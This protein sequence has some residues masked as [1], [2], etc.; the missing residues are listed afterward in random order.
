MT[1]TEHDEPIAPPP[2]S[3]RWLR[4]LIAIA[5]V[6]AIVGVLA[7]LKLWQIS[8]LA[9]FGRTKEQAGPPPEAVSTTAARTM[10]WDNVLSAVGNVTGVDS[11]A[12]S[13]DVPGI[14]TRIR[15][16]SGEIVKR[17]QLLVEL[18]AGAERAQLASARS[19][20]ELARISAARARALFRAGAIPR[21]QL[22]RGETE[23]ATAR[24]EVAALEAQLEHKLVRAP[25]SG[26]IGIRAINAGQYLAPGT[27]IAMLDAIDGLFVDFAVPQEHLPQLRIGLP[28]R[29]ELG[30]G[31]AAVPG[32]LAAIDP[33]IDRATHSVKLRA[34]VPS[35]GRAL[36]SGMFVRASVVLAERSRVLAVPATAIVHAAYGDSV[37]VIEPKPPGSPGMATT[38]DGKPVKIAR[39]QFVR[40]GR[41]RG[42]FVAIEKGLEPGAEVVTAGAFKLRNGSPVV[43]DNTR[44]ARPQL[45][46][47]PPNR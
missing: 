47:H 9:A 15:F 25:F 14:V 42:D 8:T 12:V 39:Q 38:P 23:L 44:A 18:E 40:L 35:T 34:T 31:R 30:G 11:V 37:F 13:N 21:E 26:R 45:D 46:P 3:R 6:A 33:T 28:V 7:G 16:R 43:V 36:R 1:V 20:R 5:G 32:K 17:G 41:S 4:Y 22:D 27:T 29:I 24:S 19:R 10:Q 2:R